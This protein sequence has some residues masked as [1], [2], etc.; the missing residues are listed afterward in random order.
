MSGS[1]RASEHGSRRNEASERET[2]ARN[3]VALCT[4]QPSVAAVLDDA[5]QSAIDQ[6]NP[7]RARFMVEWCLESLEG[8]LSD[9]MRSIGVKDPELGP[10]VVPFGSTGLGVAESFA[11]VDVLVGVAYGESDRPAVSAAQFFPGFSAY[12]EGMSATKD[13]RRISVV[14]GAVT[15]LACGPHLGAVFVGCFWA[16]T[17]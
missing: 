9:W 7:P 14:Q 3:T 6:T 12:L 5:L 11:D 2:K 8:L 10:L 17:R 1:A 13:I 4:M 15:W 16:F